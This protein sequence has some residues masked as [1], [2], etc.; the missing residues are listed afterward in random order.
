MPQPMLCLDADV[1][2]GAERFRSAFSKPHDESV[3]TVRRGLLEC[4]GRRTLSG[5]VSTV[6]QPPRVSG[7]RRFLSE[8]PWVA[9]A[10]VAIW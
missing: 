5:M 2:H 10:L 6:A 3:V 1:R 7:L 4:E 9:Q 8:S